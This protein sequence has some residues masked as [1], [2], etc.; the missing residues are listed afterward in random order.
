M[1]EELKP[2]VFG[3]RWATAVG[4]S[5][6]GPARDFCKC[7]EQISARPRRTTR[8]HSEQQDT[9]AP[10][11]IRLL[12][13]VEEAA[14]D[15]REE[16]KPMVE[17]SA[18]QRRQVVTLPP[19]I[20]KLTSV[21]HLV[22]YGSNLVRI[23]EE[24][25]RMASLEEFTPYTSQRLH[26]FPYELTQCPN[27]RRS[28]VSTRW[29]YGNYKLRTHF[30]PLATVPDGGH[31]LDLEDLDP[32]IW[33]AAAIRACSVCNQPIDGKGLQQ[34]W[35]SLWTSGADVVPLLVNACSTAC[36]KALPTPPEGYVR[37]PHRG[38][39]GVDQ[40]PAGRRPRLT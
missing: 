38:G 30:P 37:R 25:G 27:L 16:F 39:P 1:D 40:P 14:A 23:P 21:K 35:I 3:N 32:G 8:F 26:W 12:E 33:G 28:T 9:T 5:G 17:L 31:G 19:T 7:I 24:I 15:G 29:I 13:L 2:Q 36:I 22:L 20:A 34:V 18:E 6:D 10:G 11:W 4:P